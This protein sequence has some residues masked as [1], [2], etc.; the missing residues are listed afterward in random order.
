MEQQRRIPQLFGENPVGISDLRRQRRQLLRQRQQALRIDTSEI[1]RPEFDRRRSRL[2][3][4][5]TG[6]GAVGSAVAAALGSEVGAA[7]GEGVAI[8][9]AQNLQEQREGFRRRRRAFQ[10]QLQQA[11]QFNREVDL[12]T[13]EARVQ[14]V[15]RQIERRADQQQRQQENRQQF[16]RQKKLEELRDRLDDQL[17]DDERALLEEQ[18]E[19]QKAL[20]EERTTRADAN[21]ALAERRRSRADGTADGT[22]SG[23]DISDEEQEMRSLTDAQIAREVGLARQKL[24]GAR[25]DF[26]GQ[27]TMSGADEDRLTSRLARLQREA[28]RRGLPIEGIEIDNPEPSNGETPNGQAGQQSDGGR[29]LGPIDEAERQAARELV[30]EGKMSPLEFAILYGQQQ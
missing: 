12:S 23:G 11:Q 15:T 17:T 18:I 24:Q 19:S 10:E 29:R 22:T 20:T 25:V 3:K 21:R 2:N 13:S 7:A 14:G 6:V 9:G 4:I 5:V 1:E 27:S 28:R 26:A 16:E 30:I 8:G